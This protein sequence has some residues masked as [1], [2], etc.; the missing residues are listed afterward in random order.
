MLTRMQR[1]QTPANMPMHISSAAC[2]PG[3]DF[4]PF[5]TWSALSAC[6]WCAGYSASDGSR[7]VGQ[8][9]HPPLVELTPCLICKSFN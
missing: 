5:D 2:R 1:M 7:N 4:V 6:A 8:N 9:N 3:N